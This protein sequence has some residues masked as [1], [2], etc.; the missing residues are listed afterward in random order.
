MHDILDDAINNKISAD[1]LRGFIM[2]II[3]REINVSDQPETLILWVSAAKF[4]SKN[5]I[6]S[7]EILGFRDS[8]SLPSQS[9]IF[10]QSIR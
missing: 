8:C 4:K 10:I 1:A 2:T 3:Y 6:V 7:S 5:K 9:F